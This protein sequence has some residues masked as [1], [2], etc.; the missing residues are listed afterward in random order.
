MSVGNQGD[1]LGDN[2]QQATVS[3]ADRVV[4]RILVVLIIRHDHDE[5]VG[6]RTLGHVCDVCDGTHGHQL[7]TGYQLDLANDVCV[8]VGMGLTIVYPTVGSSLHLNRSGIDGQGSIDR[9]DLVV[10]GLLNAVA[11]DLDSQLI[12][13]AAL[14]YVGDLRMVDDLNRMAG[15]DGI[16]LGEVIALPVMS[17]TVVGPSL[18]LGNEGNGLGLHG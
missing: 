9:G 6:L 2:G 13:G 3:V 14:S 11:P 17:H 16:F 12:E 7:M 18:I 5:N 1:G 15:D 8:G 10:F 4:F